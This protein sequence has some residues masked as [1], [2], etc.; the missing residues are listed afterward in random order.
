MNLDDYYKDALAKLFDDRYL[1]AKDKPIVVNQVVATEEKCTEIAFEWL[2]LVQ[3]FDE[4]LVRQNETLKE[5][6]TVKQSASAEKQKQAKQQRPYCIYHKNNTNATD[7]CKA[8]AYCCQQQQ[9]S[10]FNH[11][12]SNQYYGGDRAGRKRT[13]P[14]QEKPVE[15]VKHIFEPKE[16]EFEEAPQVEDYRPK[17][18]ASNALMAQ[19]QAKD[20]DLRVIFKKLGVNS[21]TK[22]QSNF[23]IEE[24]NFLFLCKWTT[25]LNVLLELRQ[26]MY[27]RMAPQFYTSFGG[28]TEYC[29]PHYEANPIRGRDVSIPKGIH[30][31][32]T[33]KEKGK[34]VDGYDTLSEDEEFEG[35]L[36]E[37]Q[38]RARIIKKVV[39]MSRRLRAAIFQKYS[40]IGSARD[41]DNAYWQQGYDNANR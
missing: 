36:L 28:H 20:Q 6:T 15:E 41:L 21:N 7:N 12:M 26:E 31:D 8:L 29:F 1:R 19:L 22:S 25:M 2:Q 16:K 30:P 34:H 14:G 33:I 35:A 38:I 18:L 27:A 11:G 32:Y 23:Y 24:G 17:G 3:K 40:T 10:G 9:G 37:K 39:D 4:L 5:L 13:P